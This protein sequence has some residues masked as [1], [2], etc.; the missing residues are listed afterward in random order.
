V[1]SIRKMKFSLLAFLIL[2]SG[3]LVAQKEKPKNYHKFDNR[4]FHFGFMLGLSS[5]SYS[6]YQNLNLYP[7]YGIKSLSVEP[8]P[9]AQLGVLTTMK[10]GTPMIRLRFI[11]SI[12]FQE[13]VVKQTRINMQDSILGMSFHEY[14][15]AATTIDLPL[16]LQFRTLR[17]NN[18]TAYW[19]IGMQYSYDLQSQ[20]DA[21]QSFDDPFLKMRKHDYAGQAGIGVEFFAPYFKCGIEIKYSHSFVNGFIQDYTDASLPINK[22]YNR[23]WMFS[24]IFEG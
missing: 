5:T 18:F 11:A 7:T 12:A 1:R 4:V 3:G 24:I 19:L 6:L 10:L 23:S 20:E 16:M 17:L 2:V 21:V 14:R 8:Q 13:R 15:V 9:G 22:L